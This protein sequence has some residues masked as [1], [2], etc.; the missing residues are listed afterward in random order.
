MKL[1]EEDK[2]ILRSWNY[3]EQNIEQIKRF[4]GKTVYKFVDDENGTS[5]RI[6]ATKASELLDRKDFLSGLARST[7]HWTA[8]RELPNNENAHVFFNSGNYWREILSN[9]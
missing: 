3:T 6:S 2:Q 1:T 8:V 4:L 7:F 9:E 5:E